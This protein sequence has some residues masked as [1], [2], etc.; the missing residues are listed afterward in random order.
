METWN[1]PPV[2][3]L[4]Q[5]HGALGEPPKA[6][7]QLFCASCFVSHGWTGEKGRTYISK[8]Q[9]RRCLSSTLLLVVCPVK[10]LARVTCRGTKQKEPSVTTPHHRERTKWAPSRW[11]SVFQ[12]LILPQW[13]VQCQ[14]IHRES[15]WLLQPPLTHLLHFA[16]KSPLKSS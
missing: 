10:V 7:Q 3:F 1:T 4:R 14:L 11:T 12:H 13:P 15:Q 2:S 5:P 9:V 8:A 16:A 6:L